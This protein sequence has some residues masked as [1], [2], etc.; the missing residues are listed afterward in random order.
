MNRRRKDVK[1]KNNDDDNNN[2]HHHQECY[3]NKNKM[4]ENINR[5]SFIIRL[6]F[7]IFVLFSLCC[8]AFALG[9]GMTYYVAVILTELQITG[10]KP[11]C[12]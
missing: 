1:T 4:K 6:L 3:E 8:S 12:L 2:H 7:N 9:C 10:E 5:K 11:G